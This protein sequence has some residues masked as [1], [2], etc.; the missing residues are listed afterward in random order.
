M[1]NGNSFVINAAQNV[2]WNDPISKERAY[3]QGKVAYRLGKGNP[4]S[5]A[6]SISEYT[7]STDLLADSTKQ[8]VS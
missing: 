4:L 3:H 8:S 2:R 1:Q 5:D 7:I 6:V